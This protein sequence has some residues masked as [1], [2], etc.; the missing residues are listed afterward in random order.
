MA[1]SHCCCRT[2]VQQISQFVSSRN[3]ANSSCCSQSQCAIRRQGTTTGT[4]LTSIPVGR[5]GEKQRSGRVVAWQYKTSSFICLRV[6]R[7]FSL[8]HNSKAK[9][10]R[11]CLLQA[12]GDVNN[13]SPSI[14]LA[15]LA[16]FA[17]GIQ[18]LKTWVPHTN[19]KCCS[20]FVFYIKR[21]M[22]VLVALDN[23]FIKRIY[24][25]DEN[26]LHCLF[27]VTHPIFSIWKHASVTHN[28]HTV[29]LMNC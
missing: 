25:D 14:L 2:T 1:L 7:E 27:N 26:T 21:S 22:Y 20:I 15:T 18:C 9:V 24:D 3:I 28:S 10:D 17:L 19:R 6:F 23:W 5:Q 16:A 29:S 13:L 12:A 4:K 8:Q 11:C